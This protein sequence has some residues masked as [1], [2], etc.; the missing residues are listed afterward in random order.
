MSASES[1]SARPHGAF[2]AVIERARREAAFRG[3]V[4]WFPEE[5]IDAYRLD[6]SEARAIR[7]GDC[8]ELDLSPEERREAASV[9][10]LH[11]LH[12]GE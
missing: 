12:S 4:I 6:E 1:S 7:V 8:S 3:K 5:V 10:D 11:D 9:F 2:R